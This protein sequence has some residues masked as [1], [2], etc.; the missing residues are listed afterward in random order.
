MNF[1]DIQKD[2]YGKFEN[3]FIKTGGSN[4]KEKRL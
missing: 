3:T 4:Q 2:I 1:E